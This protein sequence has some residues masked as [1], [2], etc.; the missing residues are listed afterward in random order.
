[1]QCDT[2]RSW[3]IEMSTNPNWSQTARSQA[4]WFDFRKL[5]FSGLLGSTYVMIFRKSIMANT[6]QSLTLRSVTLC[7]VRLPAVSHCAEL[8]I[9]IYHRSK[10]VSHCG[11]SDSAVCDTVRSFAKSNLVFAALSLPWLRILKKFK[12]YVYYCNISSIQHFF[13]NILKS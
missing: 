11:E 12:I 9:K 10:M 5:Q 3:E 13:K 1:M 7:R 2:A 4:V 8:T 6:A